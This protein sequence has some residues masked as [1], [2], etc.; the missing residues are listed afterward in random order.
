MQDF[1]A[2]DLASGW[3]HSRV[4]ASP[5]HTIFEL[6]YAGFEAVSQA[7]ANWFTLL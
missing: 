3:L 4:Y 7:K 6:F 5:W 2:D 1:A